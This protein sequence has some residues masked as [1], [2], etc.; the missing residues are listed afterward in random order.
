MIFY[1]TNLKELY[2][3]LEESDPV[4]FNEKLSQRQ[5]E[6]KKRSLEQVKLWWLVLVVTIVPAM[7]AAGILIC[8]FCKHIIEDMV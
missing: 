4:R 3:V 5:I 7:L 2:K 1:S 6:D 8:T